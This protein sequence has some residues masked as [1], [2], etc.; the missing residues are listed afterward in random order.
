M[1]HR[2]LPF[3]PHLYHGKKSSRPYFEGWYF[4][5][6]SDK[7]AFSVI[8]GVFRGAN[9][10]DDIAFVQVVFGEPSKSYYFRYPYNEFKYDKQNFE[11]WIGN[12]FFSMDKVILDIDQNDIRIKAELCFSRHIPLKQSI[13]SP[14]VMGFFSYFPRMQCNHGVLSLSHT[15]NGSLRFGDK[16]MHFNDAIGYIEKDW[17]EAFPK[18]WIWMQ[19]SD[20]NSC[21]MCSIANVPFAFFNFTGLICVLLI[22]D[23][24]YRFATYNGAKVI[25]VKKHGNKVMVEIKRNRYSLKISAYNKEFSKLKAPTKTGMDRDIDESISAKYQVVLKNM[26]ETLFS[27]SFE[28][29]GLEMLS[30]NKLIK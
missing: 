22:N 25:S 8:P 19:C 14:S 10:R 2:L 16:D 15:V 21:L 28:N 18:N 11:V 17:G 1:S 9:E 12:N 4:K 23:K 20:K 26:D 5:Q 30:P 3:K 29:G 24:Q 13:F 7:Y 6:V 27:G